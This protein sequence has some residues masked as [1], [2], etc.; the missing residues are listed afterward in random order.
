M[1]FARAFYVMNF[2]IDC[3]NAA[4]LKGIQTCLQTLFNKETKSSYK[5][6]TVY[7]KNRVKCHPE[8]IELN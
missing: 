7:C 6:Y 3:I 8:T 2:S 1:R 5:D 4:N